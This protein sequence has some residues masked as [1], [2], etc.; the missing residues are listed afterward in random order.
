[1]TP[2][3]Q[4]LLQIRDITQEDHAVPA[5]T[6]HAAARIIALLQDALIAM[7]NAGFEHAVAG[8]EEASKRCGIRP[9]TLPLVLYFDDEA[10][11]SGFIKLV[12]D[13]LPGLK[14]ILIPERSK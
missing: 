11:R 12:R 5:V 10:D 7:F 6:D 14:T 2:A 4:L 13:A 3:E 9:E 8:G 1:M